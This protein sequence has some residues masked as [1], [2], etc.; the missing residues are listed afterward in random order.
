MA[1]QQQGALPPSATE[2]VLV[3]TETLPDGPVIRGYD[4]NAGR[5][6][7]GLMGA[8]LTSGFQASALGQ[9][10]VEANRMIDWRL[11]DEPVGPST[12]PEHADPAF[13]AAT[14]TK[15]YLGYTSERR[16]R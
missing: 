16:H 13:R 11:S 10:V 4:F 7:D 5:D 8:L 12:D 1:Q 14:R 15:I 3:P 6:L 9:A 2:A